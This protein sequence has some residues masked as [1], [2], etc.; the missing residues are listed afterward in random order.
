MRALLAA[1]FVSAVGTGLTLPFLVIYLHQVRH[2]S[3]AAT[4]LLIGGMSVLALPIAPVSGA[5]VDRYGPRIVMMT[6]MSIEGAGIASLALVRDVASAIPLLVVYGIGQAAVWPTWNAL[7]GVMVEDP[8]L[9]PLAFARNFQLLN[10]GIGAGSIIA[11][12]VVRVHHPDSFVTVYLVD[13]ATNL[14][15]VG[16]LALLP[17]RAFQT[18]PSRPAK[19]AA[20]SAGDGAR[21]GYRTLFDDRAFRRY[22]LTIIVMMSAGYAAINTAYVGFATTVVGTGP[23]AIAI[24]F[25][26]NTTFIVVAQP[27]ALRLSERTR[28]T[29]ALALVATAFGASWIVLALGGLWP[30]SAVGVGLV[31]ATLVVF[32]VGEV[33]LSPVNGPLVNDLAPE[34]LRGRYFAA[35]ATCFTV[36]AIVSP[37]LSGVMLGAGLGY[38]LLG[39]FVVACG[40]AVASARWLRSS[41]TPEQDNAREVRAAVRPIPGAV[42]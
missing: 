18:H 14:A 31:V 39:L 4:G 38:P 25:A 42:G 30:G 35:S 3:L 24:A 34:H 9:R 33:L 19:L 1:I 27:L 15:I 12:V 10:L 36:A 37:A 40:G 11:G 5:L 22:V 7:I 29:T 28:R 8:D 41:L 17:R 6:A 16:A 23:S 21:Q 32:A 20:G 26:F 2:I 13:G